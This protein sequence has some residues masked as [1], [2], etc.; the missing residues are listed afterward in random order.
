MNINA[1][2]PAEFEA[3]LTTTST[4]KI[5]KLNLCHYA[6]AYGAECLMCVFFFEK[7]RKTDSNLPTIVVHFSHVRGGFCHKDV[8]FFRRLGE[9]F[10]TS[11]EYT[12]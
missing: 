4:R 10:F 12:S 8:V 7:F 6:S 5:G 9:V 3:S 11:L 2:V 1:L